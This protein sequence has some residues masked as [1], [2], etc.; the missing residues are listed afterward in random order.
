[1]AIYPESSF[2][3]LS[4]FLSTETEAGIEFDN[5]DKLIDFVADYS[6]ESKAIELHNVSLTHDDLF[7]IIG[8]YIGTMQLRHLL[9]E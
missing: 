6:L 1:M 7:S 5:W 4:K 3:D 9:V 2:Q 8:Y